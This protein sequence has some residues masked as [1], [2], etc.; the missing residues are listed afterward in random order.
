MK[1]RILTLFLADAARSNEDDDVKP[2]RNGDMLLRF[3]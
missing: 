2:D 3:V 1:L